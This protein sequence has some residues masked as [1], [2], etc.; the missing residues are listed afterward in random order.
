MGDLR[1]EL[2]RV[3]SPQPGQRTRCARCSV[4]LTVM[5]GA[6]R[7][8]GARAH[9]PPPARQRQTRAR[10]SSAR[11]SAR[12]P[13]Q[14]PTP[15]TAAAPCPR[16]RAVH[17]GS[18]QRRPC[19]AVAEH[20][21]R[22]RSEAVSCS[23]SC[24]STDARAGQYARPGGQRAPRAAESCDP[25]PTEPQRRPRA[26]RHRSPPPQRDPH[27][28]IRQSRVMSPNQLNAY[29]NPLFA[30]ISAKTGAGSASVVA[31]C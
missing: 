27:P 7:P 22:L 2:P 26:P 15:V 8:D 3:R 25:S 19:C 13:R 17:P 29:K 10:R 28:D 18:D 14:A 20:S 1:G 30:G 4:T 9:Q 21:A 24:G 11:A 6:P 16:D 12:S 23:S 5:T 31:L